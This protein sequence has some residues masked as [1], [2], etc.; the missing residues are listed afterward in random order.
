MTS[1]A[2]RSVVAEQ[3]EAAVIESL[4]GMFD[5]QQQQ[6]LGV[7]SARIGGGVAVRMAAAPDIA[8]FT[9]AFALGIGEPLT[10]DVID[11]ATEFLAAAG[12]TFACLQIAPMQETPEVLDALDQ[13]GYRRGHTWAKM[14]RATGATS[15]ASTD[16]RIERL[17]ADRGE[18]M[19]RVQ[20]AG[21]EMPDILVPWS[22]RQASTPG[23]HCWG[24]FDGD[25]MVAC[26]ML[27]VHDGAG[28]LSGAATLP[29]HRGRGAQ[30]ALM[31]ARIDY[32][33]ERGL[34]WITAE[35]G[36][37]TPEEPNP[38]LHNMHRAGLELLYHRQNWIRPNA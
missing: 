17:S 31:K 2:E 36:S 27:F 32:A 7:A 19:A 34:H 26:A 22:A 10:G 8:M 12:G 14:M 11:E 1:L 30:G 6:A 13:R 25:D 3:A 21:F 33:T 24:A 38:S 16:L 28:H 5:D 29:E 18:Q 37:E 9:R 20:I 4:F 35:T 23:W 15:E